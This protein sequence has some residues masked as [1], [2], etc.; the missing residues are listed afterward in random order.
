MK[1]FTPQSGRGK[2]ILEKVCYVAVPCFTTGLYRRFMEEKAL[3]C[4]NFTN[5]MNMG[6]K[7][8]RSAARERQRRCRMDVLTTPCLTR[9]G[10]PVG[11]G[12]FRTGAGPSPWFPTDSPKDVSAVYVRQKIIIEPFVDRSLARGLVRP[13]F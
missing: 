10:K 13:L 1:H 4:H 11:E 12:R 6:R 5:N 2:R 8:C 3:L 7:Q 9:K